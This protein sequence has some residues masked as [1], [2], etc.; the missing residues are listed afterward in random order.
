V[1]AVRPKLRDRK[2][3]GYLFPLPPSKK[4]VESQLAFNTGKNIIHQFETDELYAM[5]E[6]LL[7][8]T[9]PKARDAQLR[10]IGNYKF[11][12]FEVIPLFNVYIE[13]IVDPKIVAEFS[14][15]L[16]EP[17]RG[18]EIGAIPPQELLAV[19]GW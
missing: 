6:E 12:N 5:W 3:Q 8:L 2:A 16:G 15:G 17:M 13:V 11:E 18:L 14:K 9:D 7:Q 10:K 19:R 4:A 1:A